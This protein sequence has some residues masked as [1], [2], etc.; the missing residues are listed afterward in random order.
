MNALE[1]ANEEETVTIILRAL[2]KTML[3]AVRNTRAV[4]AVG[5][6]NSSVVNEDQGRVGHSI[7]DP[8]AGETDLK[9]AGDFR[10]KKLLRGGTRSSRME[11]EKFPAMLGSS[12][13]LVLESVDPSV[14]EGGGKGVRLRERENR[15][16]GL[17]GSC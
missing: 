10:G 17:S 15:V 16:T 9:T 5:R 8:K 11:A 13:L 4:V 1:L 14:D 7:A 12:P 2:K 3:N 6:G